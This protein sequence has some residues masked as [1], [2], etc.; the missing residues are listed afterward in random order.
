MNVQ[1]L[2][3]ILLILALSAS[4]SGCT[5]QAA[6]P[7]STPLPAPPTPELPAEPEALTIAWADGGNLHVW[8]EDTGTQTLA[9][10][11][12]I[13]PVIAPDG[14]QIAFTRGTNGQPDSLWVLDRATGAGREID[15][16]HPPAPSPNGRGGE[17]LI[18]DFAWVDAG[19]LLFNTAPQDDLYRVDVATGELS[20]LLESG[21]GGRFSISPDGQRVAVVN[22]GA[23]SV[24]GEISLLD[25]ETLAL[26]SL[27]RFE[28]SGAGGLESPFYPAVDWLADSTGLRTAI[29]AWD[30]PYN[31]E[32]LRVTLWRLGVDG[33]AVT[34]GVVQATLAG[35]PRWSYTGANT[36]YLR[37]TEGDRLQLMLADAN[38]ANPQVYA[39]GPRASLSAPE[40]MPDAPLFTFRHEGQQWYGGQGMNAAVLPSDDVPV[41]QPIFNGSP[42]YVFVTALEGAY[43][44]RY[45]RR[46]TPDAPSQPIDR[47]SEGSAAVD[48]V[49]GE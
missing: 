22:P 29:P 30:G 10:S 40:W 44:I 5:L 20:Q 37:V 34:T 2:L 28:N 15:S 12:V 47:V 3:Q 11:G 17:M 33:S 36:A 14:R 8:R 31:G 45:T 26:T 9:E 25:L 4:F 38:G 46:D 48:A 6:P 18:G 42:F 16:P 1:R 21:E 39:T 49:W 27:L 43:E 41:F 7:T 13:R 35:L 19:T 24:D 32:N 23:G